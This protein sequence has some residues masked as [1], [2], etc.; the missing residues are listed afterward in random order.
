MPRIKKLNLK[1]SYTGTPYAVNDLGKEKHP[2][3]ELYDKEKKTV[4]KRSENPYDFDDYV[5]GKI[6]ER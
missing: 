1:V 3:F 5:L 6:K 2:R 4:V